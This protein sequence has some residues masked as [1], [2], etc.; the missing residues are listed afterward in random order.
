SLTNANTYTGG[1]TVEEGALFVNNSS[2]SGTGNGAVTAQA[3]TLGG[4]GTIAGPITVGTGSGSGAVLSPGSSAGV[5]SVLTIQD[6]LTFGDE[7][8]CDIQ[9]D[10]NAPAADQVAAAGVSIAGGATISLSDLGST[11]LSG[12]TSFVIIN[13]PATT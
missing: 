13:N 7:G 1:T 2:G 4:S 10:S 9:L 8:N 3:G 5:I 11:T 12:G 6:T